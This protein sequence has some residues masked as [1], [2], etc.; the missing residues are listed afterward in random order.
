M[1]MNST[2]LADAAKYLDQVWVEILENFRLFLWL[3]Y[4][5]KRLVAQRSADFRNGSRN[6]WANSGEG[7][8]SFS[9]EVPDLSG[10]LEEKVHVRDAIF[11]Y[12][13]WFDSNSTGDIRFISWIYRWPVNSVSH[14]L[15]V[16][17]LRGSGRFLF[18]VLPAI[19][20]VAGRILNHFDY[21]NT[22]ILDQNSADS[23]FLFKCPGVLFL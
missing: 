12:F 14:I 21:W 7:Q 2:N 18:S 6:I 3:D 16:C 20:R 10:S 13:L 17:G 15:Y 5:I 9:L 11:V 8:F 23:A 19:W 22:S 1:T 4:Q